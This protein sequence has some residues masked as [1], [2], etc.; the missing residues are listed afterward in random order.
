M[1][2]ILGTQRRPA[3]QL[4]VPPPSTDLHP[5]RLP[6]WP[7]DTLACAGAGL[8]SFAA[9]PA[10]GEAAWAIP[11]LA[12]GCTSAAVAAASGIRTGQ[13]NELRDNL[14]K[15]LVPH[16]G[17]RRADPRAV[18]AFRWHL[19]GGPL[20]HPLAENDQADETT[21][22][23][24]EPSWSAKIPAALHRKLGDGRWIGRPAKLKL[25]YTADVDD[26]AP[27]FIPRI[28]DTLER[29]LGV[30][31]RVTSHNRARMRITVKAVP[32]GAAVERANLVL[33]R[34]KRT[35]VQLLGPT[36]KLQKQKWDVEELVGF[37][38]SHEQGITVSSAAYRAKAERVMSTML[39]GRWRARWNLEADTVW[40]EVR[41]ALPKIVAHPVPGLDAAT[42]WRLPLAVDE[43]HDTVVWD[44][45]ST[46]PHLLIC[47]K[48][49]TGKTVAINGVVMEAALRDWP[50][51]VVDPKRIEF[52]GLRG[53]P[54]VQIVA[55]VIPE[56]IAV[57]NAAHALM[58]RRYE[59][60]ENDEASEDDFEPLILVLD[61]FRDFQGAVT[62]WYA[63]VKVT[64]MPSVC[65]VFERVSSIARKGRSA[66]IHAIIGV[67]RPDSAW[68]GGEMRDNFS[69]RLSLG[70]LSPQGAMMMWEAPHIGVSV[71]RKTAGRATAIGDN[72]QP[73]EV[74]T[75]WTPDPR[76]SLRS[77]NAEDLALLEK[78][79]PTVASHPQLKV[80][81]DPY[82]ME[83]LDD[84]GRPM[85]W[86]A[87]MHAELLPVED[88]EVDGEPF[89]EDDAE[90][91]DLAPDVV[92]V[93]AGVPE[94]G[95]E[96]PAASLVKP[97]VAAAAPSPAASPGR[98]LRLVSDADYDVPA[99]GEDEG[100]FID[101]DA[102]GEEE[103]TGAARVA[104][105][106][107]LL[108]DETEGVW[109]LVE[110]V[111]PDVLN[112]EEVFIDWRGDD[113]QSGSIGFPTSDAVSVRRPLED[114]D[115]LDEPG[116]AR[117]R[118]RRR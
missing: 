24:S 54:N 67:Q 33:T 106:D 78:L 43:D 72:D 44:L 29:R 12:L 42:R 31:Y 11:A 100:Y 76:R 86:R 85:V 83:E 15:A 104:P 98:S 114:V 26:T 94:A 37:Q 27:T 6:L 66:R 22:P 35:A 50:I 74:Q 20:S 108:L 80:H 58:E 113:D 116:Q 105:G 107:L 81:L 110:S 117:P 88:G 64:G 115:G 25:A 87:V 49:G 63:S 118:R 82:L 93:G 5:N 2:P 95:V 40:F 9:A 52:L 45:K 13:R 36:T 60:I 17:L 68:L 8:L 65:P 16:L 102:Y 19:T 96:L 59:M 111:E 61:E 90:A 41:P 32:A 112:D 39:P 109:V 1:S 89:A 91:P 84:K 57:I 21:Q 73:V 92:V 53:W 75:Y 30:Q 46:S 70:P 97:K 28:L 77:G 79:R 62:D 69:A 3:P 34:A 101:D 18:R 51:W 55:T 23:E 7:R 103:F 47:G 14:T 48:T 56:Q 10:V 71:P 99:L 38:L 4:L